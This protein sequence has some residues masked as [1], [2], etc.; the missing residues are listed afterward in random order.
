MMVFLFLLASIGAAYI[1]GWSEISFPIRYTLARHGG[2]V[3]QWFIG[4]VECPVC[5][6]TWWGLA[7]GWW[8][9]PLALPYTTIWNA[10]ATALVVAGSNLILARFGGLVVPNTTSSSGENP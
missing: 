7:C 9:N 10:I 2:R 1:V 4:L 8:W 5:F 3:G 6:G